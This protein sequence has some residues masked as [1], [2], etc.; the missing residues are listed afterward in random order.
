M[1]FETNNLIVNELTLLDAE[2]FH[3]I[4]NQP[5]ILKWMDDWKMDLE[6]VKNLLAYFITGYEIRNPEQIPFIMSI[7]TKDLKLIGICGFGSKDELGGEAEIAY[8][9][10]EEYAGNGYMSQVVEPAIEYYF[11]MTNKPY[12][13][14]LVDEKNIPSK[15]ILTKNHFVYHPVDDPN[16]ILK[17]H[18]R[19]YRTGE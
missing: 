19:C 13:C 11:T 2:D 3:R 9:M 7:R 10:D 14:A 12:L 5:Y 17:S 6:Q 16:H 4:C 18:Y 15:K 1:F 8:F